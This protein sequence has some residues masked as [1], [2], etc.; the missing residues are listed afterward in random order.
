M[1]TPTVYAE[2]FRPEP[3]ST[4]NVNLPALN[5]ECT[6]SPLAPPSRGGPEHLEDDR[7]PAPGRGRHR[8]VCGSG[9]AVGWIGSPGSGARLR[10]AP[11]EAQMVSLVVEQFEESTRLESSRGPPGGELGGRPVRGISRSAPGRFRVA[12]SERLVKRGVPS[13]G[14]TVQRDALQEAAA[15]REVDPRQWTGRIAFR[16]QGNADRESGM[17]VCGLPVDSALRHDTQ[18][19]G[20]L[21]RISSRRANGVAVGHNE[22]ATTFFDGVLVTQGNECAQRVLRET[23]ADPRPR[24]GHLSRRPLRPF[25][26]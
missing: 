16:G 26:G 18:R 24:T 1:E 6:T 19:S 13:A 4:S 5:E 21:G 11:F 14:S 2:R 12:G 9:A 23:N 25:P 7:Y 3:G 8:G 17:A 15:E 20:W 22:L 10:A